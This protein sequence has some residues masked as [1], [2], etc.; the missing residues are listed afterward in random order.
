MSF[1]GNILWFIFGGL[2]S[3]IVYFIGGILL[4]ITI[5]GIPF[6]IQSFK[7]G[8]SIL[9]P[10]GKDV[11][12]GKDANSPLRIIFNILWL[13][14]FGWELALNHLFWA[15]VLAITVIGIPF[16]LQHLKLIPLS[17]FP[18]GRHLEG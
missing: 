7:L 16:A 11:V 10:F 6:G 8:V 13:I 9:T 14:L 17:L 5:I 1:I 12:E 3:A 2:F 18:F 4:C 15:A